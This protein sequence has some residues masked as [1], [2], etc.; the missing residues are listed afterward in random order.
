[1]KSKIIPGTVALALVLAG[2]LLA[3][4]SS[5]P[6][7]Y[8]TPTQ[9]TAPPSGGTG[10]SIEL[11]AQNIA[12]DTKTITVAAGASVT[13]NF[14]N[15]DSLP[16]N[17]ALYTDS[18]AQTS[19]FVGQIIA[20]LGTTTYKFTAPAKPGNYFFRCDVHPRAMTGTFVVTP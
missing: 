9:A 4:C 6:G 11:V 13:I 3:A 17:F 14:N 7:Y 12:F 15:K 16:H 19:L 20:G 2:V 8:A 18:G 10:T 1:M 5:S